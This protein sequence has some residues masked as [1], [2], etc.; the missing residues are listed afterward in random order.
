ML[1]HTLGHFNVTASMLARQLFIL[2]VFGLSVNSINKSRRRQRWWRR[3]SIIN[4]PETPNTRRIDFDSEYTDSL[5]HL[6]EFWEKKKPQDSIFIDHA[7]VNTGND[8][9]WK[10]KTHK[11][12]FCMMFFFRFLIKIIEIKSLKTH[13]CTH[14]L[15]SS[16][17]TNEYIGRWDRKEGICSLRSFASSQ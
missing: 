6:N 8:Q 14:T 12:F 10:K 5:T 7:A 17:N 4:R 13:R 3:W 16:L 15:S 11:N 9:W 2:P 1:T